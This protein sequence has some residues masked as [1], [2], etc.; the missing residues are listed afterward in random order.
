MLTARPETRK[1]FGV[2]I[3]HL[4]LLSDVLWSTIRRALRLR[5]ALRQANLKEREFDCD[6]FGGAFIPR[7]SLPTVI[8]KP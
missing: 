4:T 1:V 6:S 5:E 8:L 7:F 3:T 2:Q